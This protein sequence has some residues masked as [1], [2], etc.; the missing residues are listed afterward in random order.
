MGEEIQNSQFTPEQFREFKLRLEQELQL[1]KTQL[2]NH[3]FD[4]KHIACGFEAEAWLLDKNYNAT[5]ANRRFLELCDHPLLSPE[6]AQFNFEINSTVRNLSGSCLSQAQRELQSIWEHCQKAATKLDL[7]PGLFGILPTINPADLT[8]D[9][10]SDLNRYAALNEQILS[11]RKG[12]PLKIDISGNQH[13]RLEHSDVMLESAATSF[14]LHLQIPASVA[15]H[16]YNAALQISAPLLA[17]ATNS[18]F[19][20]GKHLFNETRIPLFEQAVELGGFA[21]AAQ[22][23]LKRVGFGSDYIRGSIYKV[24]AENVQHFPVLLP[25]LFDEPADAL[26]HLRFHN[27][28][29]WRWNRPLIGNDADSPY[30]RLEHRSLPA[31]PTLSDMFA[32]AALF[33]GLIHWFGQQQIKLQHRLPF[34]TVKDNFYK[35]AQHGLDA[36]ITWLDDRTISIRKLIANTLLPMAEEGLGE[37]GVASK[38]RDFYLGIIRARNHSG[39]TGSDWQYRFVRRTGGDM[40]LLTKTYLQYQQKG[41]PVHQWE[42]PIPPKKNREPKLLIAHEVPDALLDTPANQ[43]YKILQEPTL[44]ALKGQAKEAVFV[45]VLLHGNEDTGLLAAQRILKKYQHRSLPRSLYLFIGNI[46]AAR[47]GVRRLSGQDD[48]NR[49]WP[50]SKAATA[51]SGESVLLQQVYD[52]AAGKSLFASIDIHNNTGLN[53]QYACV[54]RMQ[55][56]F[57]NLALL[58]SRTVVYFIRPEG[59]QSSTFAQLCPATTI[60]C[61]K[62]GDET[63]IDRAQKFIDVCLNLRQLPDARIK[64]KD[65]DLFH[66]FA[67]VKIPENIQFSFE[68]E[69][70]DIHFSTDLEHMNFREI[71]AGTPIADCTITQAPP[72]TTIDEHGKD[73][74]SKYFSIE[75]GLLHIKRAVVPSMLTLNERVIRQDCFC[76]LMKRIKPKLKK[77]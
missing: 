69:P 65:I 68:D 2:Q 44:F 8:L 13:L 59:V 18:C 36:K 45:S 4:E 15:A 73:V 72:L 77:Q 38:D 19:L 25:T 46:E 43:L 54:N 49:H 39:Q 55:R 11:Q 47:Y 64:D 56:D 51:G 5:S 3:M 50:A 71:S 14:Q 60:E 48:Y 61:G 24:F 21:A 42:L 22:G 10:I 23:P 37:L 57:L 7:I 16:Y 40:Q 20:F 75:N 6:L 74:F 58:F 12:R 35:A 17:I 9:S 70:A 52:W 53:P 32:N 1:F 41:K 63:G 27:G 29:I 62:V 76:Y 31:G 26:K 34:A 66:T 30:I 28:T 33:Y 67:Q